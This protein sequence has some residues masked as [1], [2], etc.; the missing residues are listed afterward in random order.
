MEFDNKRRLELSAGAIDYADVGSGSVLVFVHGVFVNGDLWRLVAPELAADFRCIV[1]T[2]PLGAHAVPMRPDA[3]LSPLGLAKLIAEVIDKLELRDVTLVGNDTGGALCQLVIAHHPKHITRI[4]L[5][6][7]DAMEYFP[8]ASLAPIY[9]I[10]RIPGSFGLLAGA[11][12]SQRAQ[13]IFFATV[14]KSKPDKSFLADTFRTFVAD[15]AV[16]RDLQ[17]TLGAVSKRDTLAAA[18]TFAAF[19]GRTLVVWGEDDLFFPV[20][21]G[22]RLARKFPNA[23]LE[24]IENCRTLVPMDAPMRLIS[25][26]RSFVGTPM[27]V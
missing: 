25:S 9:L 15:G 23:S 6:N 14:A 22:E 18:D 10:A 8:P 13:A 5:T 19:R 4:V 20:K 3:D 17:K 12:R 27:A 1:L 24:L 26:I 21:L 11:L 7:C 2:L 16:R